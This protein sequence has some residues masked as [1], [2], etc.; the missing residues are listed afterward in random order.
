[1]PK[2]VLDGKTTR[3]LAVIGGRKL[4]KVVDTLIASIKN[5]LAFKSMHAYSNG[6][7]A[8]IEIDGKTVRVE[9]TPKEPDVSSGYFKFQDG[10]VSFIGPE[11]EVVL[12]KNAL[13]ELAKE[14]ATYL[15]DR[16]SSE[17]LGYYDITPEFI[18][19]LPQ[20]VDSIEI[21]G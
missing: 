8:F 19:K 14:R 20:R 4:S 13:Y 2:L 3:A 16:Y 1:M 10:L 17:E 21:E 12:I 11:A 18:R 5:I 7:S 9:I 6:K 15:L